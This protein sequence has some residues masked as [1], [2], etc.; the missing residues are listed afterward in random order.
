[1]QVQVKILPVS[2]N[3]KGD[4]MNRE[5]V[6]AVLNTFVSECMNVVEFDGKKNMANH[7]Y[8]PNYKKISDSACTQILYEL[9]LPTEW[10]NLRIAEGGER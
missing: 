8:V 9:G 4:G 7:Y 10:P 1:M 6:I 2:E 5:K 3:L